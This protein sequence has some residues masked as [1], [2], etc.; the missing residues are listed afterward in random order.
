MDK[1]LEKIVSEIRKDIKQIKSDVKN[2]T[3]ETSKDYVQGL[4]DNVKEEEPQWTCNYCGGDMML[5]EY[6]YIG[7]PWPKNLDACNRVG[8]GGFSLR[9]KKFLEVSA[10]LTYDPNCDHVEKSCQICAEDWFL[11]VCNYQHMLN[12]KIK[13]PD[14]HTALRFA[15][16][17][18]TYN[19]FGFHG[20]NNI[21]AMD[22][23]KVDGKTS[24]ASVF[25]CSE[26]AERYCWDKIRSA[27]GLKHE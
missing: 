27:Q 25:Q 21:A 18:L 8:N 24:W 5:V 14:V 2:L 7:A 23:L 22:L 17:I 4:I 19:S 12:K 16:D 3:D 10:E 15:V 11:C 20:S 26:P 13:F 1:E 6:D 9:S